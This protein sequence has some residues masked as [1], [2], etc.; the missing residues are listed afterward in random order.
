M[1]TIT[2]TR[3]IQNIQYIEISLLKKIFFIKNIK[4]HEVSTQHCVV[5]DSLFNFPL[6]LR[7]CT[8]TYIQFTTYLI[9]I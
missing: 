8:T 4:F 9:S 5:I 1:Q 2:V 6:L 7:K 3:T